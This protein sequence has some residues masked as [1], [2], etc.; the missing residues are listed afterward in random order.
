MR[1]S[2]LLTLILLSACVEKDPILTGN[3]DAGDDAGAPAALV[4]AAPDE[5]FADP[6]TCRHCAEV[7]S[8][9]LV[10]GA[11]CQKNAEPSSSRLANALVDC[12]CFDNCVSTCGGFC[13]GAALDSKCRACMEAACAPAVVACTSDKGGGS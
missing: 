10:R 3:R 8:A 5:P 6:P 11:L 9:S 2:L 1:R 4:T 7:L 12:T 13:S